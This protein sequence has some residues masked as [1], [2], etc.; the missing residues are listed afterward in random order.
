MEGKVAIVTGGAGGLGSEICRRFSMRGAAVAVADVNREAASELAGTITSECGSAIG[1]QVEVTDEDSVIAAVSTIVNELGRVDYLVHC[2]GTNIKSPVLDMTLDQWNL[3]LE[4]HL[5]GAFLFCREAGKRMVAQGDGGSVVLMSSVTA[6]SP[7]PERG[8]YGPAKAALINF[9]GQL[10]LE[11]AHY[12]INVNAVCPGV[13]VTPMTEMVYKREPELR[14]Q[15]LKR[16]PIKREV[17]PE[18]IADL[19]LFLCSDQARYINGVGIPIDGGF[20]NSGF[21]QDTES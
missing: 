16:F 12:G 8:A 17:L 6:M 11:W 13:A 14:E 21:Y 2:A 5:T 3:S 1:V 4:A 10:G 18:E 19:V 9:A 20:L 15:R 7:V